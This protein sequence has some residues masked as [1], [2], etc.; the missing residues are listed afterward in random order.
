MSTAQRPV[1]G[2][3]VR[4]A[5]SRGRRLLTRPSTPAFVGVLVAL[6]VFGAQAPQ[7]VGT[8]GLASLLD[9]AALIGIG[10][11]AV[12]LLLVAGQFD[13]SIGV[14]SVA[15]SVTAGLLVSEAGWGV[16]PALAA[17]LVGALAVG[18]VNGLLV[19]LTGLPSFLVTLAT[20]LVLQGGT[21]V[22]A[23]SVAGTSLVDRVE[24]A[25]GWP[26]AEAL[27]G[28]GV[29]LG[30][31]RFRISILWWLAAVVLAGWLLRRTRFGNAIY[32]L[33]GSRRAAR[34]M[35]VPTA[36]TTVALYLLTATAA[37][38]LGTLALVRQGG[39]PV[40]PEFGDEIEYLVVAVI[41]GCLL[42]GGYGSAVGAAA[43]ALLYGTV[44]TGIDI[45]GWE[46]YSF[47]VVL[48]VL[49]VV[50]LLANGVARRRLTAVPRS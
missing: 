22:V 1:F 4:R 27:F 38:L 15:S 13:V 25:A 30:G 37:W 33:G 16:W 49:L 43:G 8:G 14:L 3:P 31:G 42:G 44:R 9:A 45:A 41:G 21:L 46:S 12:T 39:V 6:V 29:A 5:P 2:V 36:S 34:E 24:G 47:Q 35:G 32:A 26:S 40:A 28:S 23:Q 18:V 50:A 48:G 7:L 10:A 17:S 11:V 19:V 20:F